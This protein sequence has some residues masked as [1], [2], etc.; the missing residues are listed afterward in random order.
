MHHGLLRAKATQEIRHAAPATAQWNHSL[1]PT[2]LEE[3]ASAPL[4]AIFPQQKE[5]S[6]EP[7]GRNAISSDAVDC[8]KQAAAAESTVNQT[9]ETTARG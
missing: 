8:G 7:P 4:R 9:F 3:T 2:P 5:T 6:G 1:I